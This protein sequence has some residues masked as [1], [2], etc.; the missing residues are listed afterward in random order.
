MVLLYS[1]PIFQKH[2]T[3]QHPECAARVQRIAAHLDEEGLAARCVRPEWEL[4]SRAQL[5]RVHQPAY[6]DSVERFAQR[7]GG[8]VES[9]TAVS[10]ESFQVACSAA[11][12]TVDATRRVV[13][14]SDQHALCLVRPPGH[15]A[16][17]TSAMGFC[18]FNNIAV[19]ARVA[20]AELQLDRVLI[21]DWDVHHGNGTQATFW[22]DEQVG[23]L[24]IH[25]SPFYPGT[26]AADETG[27]GRGLGTTVNVPVQFGTPRETYLD[28]F[29][30]TLEEIA[31]RIRPQLVMI[32]AGFD[33]HAL[34]PVGSLG[35]ED[36]DFQ[37]LTEMVLAVADQH[38]EGRVVS[39][40]EGGYNVDVLPG[41]VAVHL[42][43]LLEHQA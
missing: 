6:V 14:G 4:A 1:N 13:A 42:A 25:R 40:L 22:E 11:G 19:A 17:E 27:R 38:A 12:A 8:F 31:A 29:R 24:S 20:T 39:V 26:G 35:L 28:Q 16:L 10:P 3:G 23:F 9:D 34:D 33:T 18:L 30:G 32:S 37:K 2:E 15:H 7:G 41:S 43:T 21:V 36:E 5:V